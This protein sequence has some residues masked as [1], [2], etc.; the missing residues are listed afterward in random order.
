MP[1]TQHGR[2]PPA[3]PA[4]CVLDGGEHDTWGNFRLAFRPAARNPA[5]MPESSP[6]SIPEPDSAL[7]PDG[8][9][10]VVPVKLV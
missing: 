7:V 5:G 1:G 6:D 9:G 10:G 3:K 4:L 8:P 2:R